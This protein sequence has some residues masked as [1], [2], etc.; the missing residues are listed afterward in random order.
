MKRI[1]LS[2]IV[3]LSLFYACDKSFKD[4][5]GDEMARLNAWIE[6]HHIPDST[7][8]SSGLYYICDK[9]GTG[10]SPEVGDYVI[11]SF[12]EKNLDGIILSSNDKATS[13]LYDEYSSSTHYEPIFTE[14]ENDDK[15]V[16]GYSLVMTAGLFEGLGYMKEGG[17]ATLIMPSTLAHGKSGISFNNGEIYGYESVIYEVELLKVVKDPRAYEK[18]ILTDYINQNYPGLQPIDD[19]IYY[20]QLSAPINDTVTIVNDTT[21]CVYYKGMFLDGFV[22][23]TNI[24][25]VADRLD[26]TFSS[27]DSLE[28]TVGSS[29]QI[30]GFSQ[31][32]VNM[33]LGEW[34]RVIMP[35]YC[36]YDSTGSTSIPPYKTLIFDIYV[37]S[38]NDHSVYDDA[39]EK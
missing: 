22:F 10:L 17:K 23:D 2:T 29:A 32:L 11:Y 6:V 12:K 25:S 24:D 14:Y 34:S 30:R 8:K 36:A 38:I 31:A 9:E 18:G 1:I 37:C 5:G 28:V 7:L 13:I 33:K 15:S 4:Y 19:S 35:S 20:V 39:S 27:T 3:I 21:V 26:R 16:E